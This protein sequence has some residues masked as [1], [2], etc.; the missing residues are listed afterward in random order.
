[1]HLGCDEI[2]S[3][4]ECAATVLVWILFCTNYT[5]TDFNVLC[6]CA[7]TFDTESLIMVV[8]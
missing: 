8:Y 5:D 7:V 3:L 6:I 2:R 4:F 1:M